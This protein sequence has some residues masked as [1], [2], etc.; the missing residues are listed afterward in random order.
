MLLDTLQAH[1]ERQLEEK[2]RA[3]TRTTSTIYMHVFD[4]DKRDAANKMDKFLRGDNK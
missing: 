1:A 4:A 3:N 2:E